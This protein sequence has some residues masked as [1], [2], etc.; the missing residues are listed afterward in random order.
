[1]CE[2][3]KSAESWILG[4][5]SGAVFELQKVPPYV[6]KVLSI[7]ETLLQ[8]KVKTLGDFTHQEFIYGQMKE[9]NAKSMSRSL[10]ERKTFVDCE[11]I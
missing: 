10:N 3:I 11:L 9:V 2:E 4:T 1:M 7:V 6:F 8:D 5:A